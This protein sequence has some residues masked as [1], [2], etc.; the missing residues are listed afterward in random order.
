MMKHFFCS[1][2]SSEK[3]AAAQIDYITYVRFFCHCGEVIIVTRLY[4]CTFVTRRGSSRVVATS[5]TK[6]SRS[7]SNYKNDGC[8]CTEKF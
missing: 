1:I 5:D 4:K 7:R 3:L 8:A 6:K 2:F